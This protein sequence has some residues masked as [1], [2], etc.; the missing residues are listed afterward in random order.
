VVDAPPEVA[1]EASMQA[2]A[3]DADDLEVPSFLRRRRPSAGR[4]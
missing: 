4:A 2:P 1:R 3:G